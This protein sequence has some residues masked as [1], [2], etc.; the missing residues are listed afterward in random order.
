MA[1]LVE[2]IEHRKGAQP[3]QDRLYSWIAAS[4]NCSPRIKTAAGKGHKADRPGRRLP[5]VAA[6][7]V[8]LLDRF[9]GRACGP[10]GLGGSNENTALDGFDRRRS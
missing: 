10:C 7:P 5:G 8:R 9:A 6:C 1:R 3:M 4:A 2:Q